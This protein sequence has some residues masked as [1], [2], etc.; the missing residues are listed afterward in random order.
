[1]K[2][3]REDR[4]I[5]LTK[6]AIRESLIE[7]MQEYPI[8]KISVKMLCEAADINRSTFYAHYADQYD[9]LRQV[10][11]EVMEGFTQQIFA[12]HLTAG[13]EQAV[14]M[15]VQILDYAKN[16]AELFMLLM[17]EEGDGDFR[18]SL[19]IIAQ[20][21]AIQE[22]REDKRLDARTAAYLE[23]FA[24]SGYISIIRKWLEDGCVDEPE[25]LA[26][27]MTKL[28]FQGIVSVFSE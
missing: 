23:T 20:Q 26:E 11:Q 8:S 22:I 7:L 16:N 2:G 9:L 25:P 14:S 28:L 13:S 15:L 19:I 12:S 3:K 6:Q 10:Q 4:R 27:L 18:R 1:M 5:R 21:K 17:N 24:I